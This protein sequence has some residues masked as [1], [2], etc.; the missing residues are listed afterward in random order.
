MSELPE[1]MKAI[2]VARAGGPEVLE[3]VRRPTPTPA[4][5]EV[6]IEVAAAGLNRADILQRRGHYPSP[7]GAPSN[8]GLEGAGT[9]VAMGGAV[10]E[11]QNGDKVCARLQGG[12]YSP[13]AARYAALVPAR[14]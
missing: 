2:D 1:T 3:I 10:R 13:A 14:S 6:L 11:C 5:E 7:P 8:P 12:G 4:D 9:V